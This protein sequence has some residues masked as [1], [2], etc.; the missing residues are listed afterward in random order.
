MKLI[1]KRKDRWWHAAIHTGKGGVSSMVILRQGNF[2]WV[3]KIFFKAQH[4]W[5]GLIGKKKL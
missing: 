1:L 5:T 2:W 3:V 4:L